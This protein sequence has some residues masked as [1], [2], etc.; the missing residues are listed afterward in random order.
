MHSRSSARLALAGWFNTPLGRSL[1]SAE[2]AQLEEVLP[3]L[4]GP[5]ALQLGIIDPDYLAACDAAMRI[6][7]SDVAGARKDATVLRGIPESLPFDAKSVGIVVMPHVLECADDPHQVLREVSRVLVPEGH[8]VLVGFNPL[9]LWGLRRL[10]ATAST[11]FPWAGRF[12]RLTRVKDW[13]A[14][15]DFEILGGRMLYYRPPVT[16][17]R[18]RQRLAFVESAG[19]RWWPLLAAVYIVVARKREI[20]LIPLRP[21]KRSLRQLAPGL[22]EPAVQNGML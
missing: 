21:E 11:D 1:A 22:P 16:S 3:G 14:L 20:G 2:R 19:D 4:Y 17:E 8:V 7:V 15:L 9:S 18:V 12:Y 10:L 13:L 6:A 5:I